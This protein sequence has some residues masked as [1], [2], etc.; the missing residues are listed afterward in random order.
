MKSI[1]QE[2]GQKLAYDR[3]DRSKKVKRSFLKGFV[4]RGI[5]LRDVKRMRSL[6]ILERTRG[7]LKKI[8]HQIIKKEKR[9]LKEGANN[10]KTVF[11]SILI[12]LW[13]K[14]KKNRRLQLGL[15]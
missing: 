2:G 6:K 13:Q 1:G 5:R 14:S 11:L 3:S 10:K 8:D 12:E 15:K 4:W 9:I 7:F